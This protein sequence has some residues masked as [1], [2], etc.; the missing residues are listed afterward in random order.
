MDDALNILAIVANFVYM[1]ATLRVMYL[2]STAKTKRTMRKAL[3]WHHVAVVSTVIVVL[4][5]IVTAADTL[6]LNFCNM[7]FAFVMYMILS[8]IMDGKPEFT[9]Q[10]LADQR[11]A[12]AA[13]RE[14][15]DIMDELHKTYRTQI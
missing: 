13:E 10:E 2:F 3:R 12:L 9:N 15:Q 8:M 7:G 5:H 4:A 11:K 14:Q 1:A 6:V